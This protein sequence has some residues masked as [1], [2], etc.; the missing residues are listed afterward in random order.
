MAEET[1]S[2]LW[3]GKVSA[4][5]RATKAETVWSLLQDFCSVHKWLPSLDTCY[6]VEGDHGQPGLVRYCG[7]TIKSASDSEEAITLWCHEKLVE[8]D[9]M[10][11]MLSY[12]IMENN[13]GMKMYKSTIRVVQMED[14]S[15]CE[16]K[17]GFVAEPVE[18]WKFEDLVSYIESSL[19]GMAERM[20]KALQ[21]S[22][23]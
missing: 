19:H 17:W 23:N 20:E 22:T 13:M 8:M 14:E 12:E 15:G 2:K 1:N 21:S 18:G 11:K 9:E 6:K 10:E 7:S 3:E 4:K 5:V 16:I